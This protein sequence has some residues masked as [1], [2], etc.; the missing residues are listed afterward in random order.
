MIIKGGNIS[1]TVFPAGGGL[2]NEAGTLTINNV[3]VSDSIAF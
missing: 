2:F 1:S 3:T